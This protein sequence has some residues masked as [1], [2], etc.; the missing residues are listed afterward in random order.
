[1]IKYILQGIGM[2]FARPKRKD[3]QE[4]KIKA[5][6]RRAEEWVSKTNIQELYDFVNRHDLGEVQ[7]SV[8]SHRNVW[9]TVPV[10]RGGSW[11]KRLLLFT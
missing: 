10:V 2:L 7:I 4:I 6:K 3:V 8:D 1:M 9:W 11:Q 5:W